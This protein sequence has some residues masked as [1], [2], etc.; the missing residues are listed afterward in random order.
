VQNPGYFPFPFLFPLPTVRH[1]NYNY[2][3]PPTHNNQPIHTHSYLPATYIPI[4]HSRSPGSY[5]HPAYLPPHLTPHTSLPRHSQQLSTTTLRSQLHPPTH[6][7][8]HITHHTSH[9][10]HHT[11]HITHHTSNNIQII[12]AQHKPNMSALDLSTTICRP[13][14][15]FLPPCFLIVTVFFQIAHLCWTATTH[16]PTHTCHFLCHHPQPKGHSAL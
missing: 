13:W 3:Y 8:S 4:S 10:T 9:I 7:T 11:S 14:P 15:P 5:P 16:Y 6:H 1:Y 12:T 2:W